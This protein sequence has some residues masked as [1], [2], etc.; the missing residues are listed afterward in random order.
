[1]N[2][3]TIIILI[4]FLLKLTKSNPNED[5]ETFSCPFSNYCPNKTEVPIFE[6]NQT[7]EMY[8][9]QAPLLKPEL[10]NTLAGLSLYHTAIGILEVKSN[11]QYFIEF[12]AISNFVNAVFPNL[13]NTTNSTK[14]IWCDTAH[15]CFSKAK[16]FPPESYFT[17]STLIGKMNGKIFN[18]FMNW[19]FDYNTSVTS[20]QLFYA[21]ELWPQQEYTPYIAS[22]ACYN[23]VWDSLYA[24]NQLGAFFLPDLKL[25][26]DFAILH[27]KPPVVVNPKDPQIHQEIVDFYTWFDWRNK[28]F[29]QI[30]KDI[31]FFIEDP[32]FLYVNGD[33][34]LIEMVVPFVSAH[35]AVEEL[36]F[37][38]KKQFKFQSKSK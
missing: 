34:F 10:N 26:H 2:K 19:V 25:R 38:S 20:Y 35:Y 12:D 18:D 6:A 37:D 31:I 30:I 4:I 21:M 3:F 36:S 9:L 7:I 29:E 11:E 15:V 33:Y 17:N 1:M 14:I 24:L 8:F 22:Q 16:I 23:F 5:L 32:K 13:V 27:T 28:T